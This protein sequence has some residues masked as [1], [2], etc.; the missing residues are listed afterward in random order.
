MC[1]RERS[2][3]AMTLGQSAALAGLFALL[4]CA[5][6]P[7][8]ALQAPPNTASQ[9]PSVAAPIGSHTVPDKTLTADSVATPFDPTADRLPA[10]FQGHNV[11]AIFTALTKRAAALA[12]DEFES[13]A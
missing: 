7:G 2:R 9:E 11:E 5:V 1:D 8:C 12:K 6:P 10:D 13:T 3:S 4:A